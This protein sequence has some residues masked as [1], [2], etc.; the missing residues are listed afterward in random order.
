MEYEGFGS[1]RLREGNI[2]IQHFVIGHHVGG[3]GVEM[4]TLL[5]N[6]FGRGAN[7]IFHHNS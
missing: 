5:Q 6:I 3:G 1:L 4:P 7:T 2:K